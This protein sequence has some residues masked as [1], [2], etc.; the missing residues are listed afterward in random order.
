[1]KR[2]VLKYLIN[3]DT[4]KNQQ[5][6]KLCTFKFSQEQLK[7]KEINNLIII[8]EESFPNIKNKKLQ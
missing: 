8:P 4:L 2:S 7:L 5:Y 3:S 1:M 6:L